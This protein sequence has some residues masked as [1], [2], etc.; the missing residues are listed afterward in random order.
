MRGFSGPSV[1]QSKVGFRCRTLA[2]LRLPEAVIK[3]A[4][5]HEDVVRPYAD[6]PPFVDD[7]DEIGVSERRKPVRNDERRASLHQS[8]QC[9]LYLCLGNRIE[10][11][12]R[13]V[14]YDQLCVLEQR[15]RDVYSLNL[16]RRQQSSADT[17]N[18]VVSLRKLH[19]VVV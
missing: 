6:A 2:G 14:E 18:G 7:D 15:T 16:S 12:G 11:R 3:L 13:L 10:I 19:D 4:T 5:L 1:G 17:D 8:V 9:P